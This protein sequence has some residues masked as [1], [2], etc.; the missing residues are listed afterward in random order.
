ML[1][2]F[3]TIL[4]C[5]KQKFENFNSQT[6]K[7]KKLVSRILSSQCQGQRDKGSSPSGLIVFYLTQRVHLN[8]RKSKR[9]WK[10][11]EKVLARDLLKNHATWIQNYLLRRLLHNI[12]KAKIKLEVWVGKSRN[13]IFSLHFERPDYGKNYRSFHGKKCPTC[14]KELVRDSLPWVSSF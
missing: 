11:M 2:W 12:F 3:W 13:K 14:V 9:F 1:T 7:T 6:K 8:F 5:L 4:K 10:V